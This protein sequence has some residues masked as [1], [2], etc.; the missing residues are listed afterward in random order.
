MPNPWSVYPAWEHDSFTQVTDHVLDCGF[1]SSQNQF[2]F[3]PWPGEQRS[4]AMPLGQM[5]HLPPWAFS[6]YVFVW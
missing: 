4:V 1:S 2:L 6:S 5:C 3:E